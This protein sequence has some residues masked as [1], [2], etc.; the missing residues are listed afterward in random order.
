MARLRN[1]MSGIK[2]LFQK[3]Q[4]NRE[5]DEELRGYF[6]A[7]VEEKMR[8]GIPRDAA[9]RAACVE[10]GSAAVVR[11]RVWSA[12]WESDV[13]SLGQ[14]VRFGM[15][16]LL[17]S[18]GFSLVAILS[19]ALGIGANTAIFTLINDLLLKSLPVHEPAQLVSFGKSVGGGILGSTPPG[20]TDTFTYDFYKR[21]QREHAPFQR[22]AAFGSFP[23]QVSVRRGGGE[24]GA[25]TQAWTGL[26]SDTFFDVLGVE[27]ILGR[28][29][30][31]HD[32][33]APRRNAV[34]VISHRYWQQALSADPAVIGRT[35]TISGTLFTVVGVM[36]ARFYGVELN[37]EMPDMWVPLTMQQPV[38]QQLQGSLLEPNGMFWLHMIARRKPGVNVA[39]AQAWTTTQLQHYLGDREG[40]RVSELR[41]R[42]IASSYVPLLPIG[43]GISHLRAEY[44]APLAVLMGVVV[45]VLLIACANVANFLLAKAAAREREFTTRLALGSSR[46]RIVRQIL[47]ET[48]LLAFTGGTIGLLLAFAGTR[49]LIQ[50]VA[51]PDA[52]TALEATPDLHVLVFTWAICLLTG[53]LFGLAPALSVSHLST[54]NA[55]NAAARTI[56]AAGGRSARPLPKTLMVGQVMLSLV[57]LAVAGLFV[58]TLH[59][60]RNRDLGFNQTNLLL[61]N[62]NPRFAGYK[63]GQLNALYQRILTRVDA[64]PGVRSTAL[65]GQLPIARGNWGSP[66]TIIGRR[67]TPNEDVS[68]YLQRVSAG[69]F[70]TLGIPLLRGRTINAGDTVTS[71]KAV[72]V[73]QTLANLYFPHGDA[74]GHSFTVGDPSV[75]GTWQIVGVVRDSQF[76]A[77]AKEQEAMAYLAVTQLT[78][79]DQYAYWLQVQSAGDPAHLIGEVR[80]AFAEIDPSLP[81][82]K[83]ETIREQTESLIDTQKLV[84]QLSSFFSLLA[85]A[86][87]CIGLYGVMMYSVVRRTNEIGVRIALGAPRAGVLWMVLRESLMLLGIGIAVGVPAMLAACRAVQAGLFGLEPW[88]PLTLAA[89]VLIIALVTVMAA[90][91]R[92]GVRPRSI[93]W[94]LCVTNSRRASK[95][96]RD[97]HARDD[98]RPCAPKPASTHPAPAW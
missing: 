85:L 51:G 76:R 9:E 77:G 13:E 54:S 35:L 28:A 21:I 49:A 15:R 32:I 61:V 34:A 12:N 75:K 92:R 4:R 52:H 6:E 91:F 20:A 63:P 17:K 81:I 37:E 46:M 18:P 10:A 30:N 55:L 39:Q 71:L 73:N 7:A 87:S 26:V 29:L 11:H 24:S 43:A 8:R 83:V 95:R 69:Y 96:W 31:A 80:A 82:L 70:E 33:E 40:T 74:V 97:G 50:F 45:L 57:L 41:R 88:D 53:I 86:L 1:L 67:T 19:L 59:N 16:Q 84:S 90:L 79:D 58:R 2:A 64:L 94:W 48:L 65:S 27:P 3:E 56:G 89:A 14:D 38:L 36:P 93:R 66:I 42:E 22:V 5:I 78:E 60:L 98:G 62:F 47:T 25:A 23:I 68:T 44:E 72:V